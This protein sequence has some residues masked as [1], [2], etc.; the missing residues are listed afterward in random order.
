LIAVLLQCDP[1]ELTP[2]ADAILLEQ[3]LESCFHQRFRNVDARS[4][5]FIGQPFHYGAQH[6]L[7]AARQGFLGIPGPG[8][9]QVIL[10]SG[11]DVEL[12][13]HDRANGIH[14]QIWRALFQKHSRGARLHQPADLENAE[15]RR[16]NQNA[17][18]KSVL[19][20][21]LE[22]L[23]TALFPKVYIQQNQID[24]GG[25]QE[26]QRFFDG[27]ATADNFK[28][29]FRIEQTRGA[30]PEQGVIVNEKNSGTRWLRFH[31]RP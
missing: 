26:Y 14:Q 10:K 23:E 24:S 8:V 4:D 9:A 29:G 3:L 31:T 21:R 7:F 5:F 20:G 19:S 22:K 30:L 28:I 12:P 13:S 15:D 1:D 6:G 16:D 11:I 25:P 2:G 18:R 17:S 27:A